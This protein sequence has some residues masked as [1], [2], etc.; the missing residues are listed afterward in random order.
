MPPRKNN[1]P[2]DT[3]SLYQIAVRALARRAHSSAELRALLLRRK[4]AKADVEAVLARLRD[5]GFLDDVRFARSFVASR[6]EDRLE[7]R[8]RVRRDL[9]ARRVRPD[10]ADEAL[11]S[12]FEAVDEAQLLRQYLRRKL[13]VSKPLDKPSAVQGLYRRLL[14]AGFRS[15]TIVG[16]L[17]PLLRAAS[18][19]GADDEPLR[20][21]ELLD[22]LA[23]TE[24]PE[25]EPRP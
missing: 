15:D 10:V 20:W 3:D 9:A 16:E 5:H 22:S 7:G 11:H 6:I 21:D 2:L 23:E 12:G 13:R 24:E 17:K 25:S 18:R 8:A 4:A 14:R 19:R 1:A